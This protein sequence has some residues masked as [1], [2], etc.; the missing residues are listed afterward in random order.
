MPILNCRVYDLRYKNVINIVDGA[1]LGC[2]N[3]IEIDTSNAKITSVIIYGKYK[4]FG[5]LGREKDILIPWCD[6][7]IIGEDA[8]LVKYQQPEEEK[9][10][11]IL[12][13]LPNIFN[14]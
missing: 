7:K 9:Q 2:V 12:G 6:I 1:V 4:L 10:Q 11:K 14:K 5:L 13:I 8:V 3:D